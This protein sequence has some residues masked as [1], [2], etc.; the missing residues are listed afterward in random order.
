M[1]FQALF[2]VVVSSAI[3]RRNKLILNPNS[4]FIYYTVSFI[5]QEK[6]CILLLK[7]LL[8]EGMKVAVNIRMPEGMKKVLD[9]IAEN[10]FRSLNSLILQL[11]N[12]QLKSK[13]IDWRKE[14]GKKAKK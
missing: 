13:A 10:E 7:G 2:L 14:S 1:Y 5:I 8:F 9:N 4:M 11:L 3:V 6:N 12:D